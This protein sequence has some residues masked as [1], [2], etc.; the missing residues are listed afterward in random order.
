MDRGIVVDTRKS[1][2]SLLRPVPIAS[3][4]IEDGFWAPRRRAMREAGLGH[5]FKMCEATGRIDNFRRLSNDKDVP[6][7]GRVFNDSD[8]YK[9]LEA[10]SHA[11]A[12]RITAIPIRC[13]AL[14]LVDTRSLMS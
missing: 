10:A 14:A 9:L 2:H 4:R 12:E 6:F 13:T 7:R 1:P 3:A 11:L 8:V 5:Q